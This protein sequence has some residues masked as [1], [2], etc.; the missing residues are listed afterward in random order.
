MFSIS[1][2]SMSSPRMR[3]LPQKR[4]VEPGEDT[5][6]HDSEGVVGEAADEGGPCWIGD[7]ASCGRDDA[8]GRIALCSAGGAVSDCQQE[9]IFMF[10][11]QR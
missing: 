5:A 6:D 2:K 11:G 1:E 8:D 10:S 9:D 3:N 7:G 4:S